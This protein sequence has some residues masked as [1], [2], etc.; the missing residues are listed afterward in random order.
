[1]NVNLWKQVATAVG[2]GR[3]RQLLASVPDAADAAGKVCR[4]L[5]STE[6][7]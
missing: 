1:M 7:R 5:S 2:I 4:R 6:N 3:D